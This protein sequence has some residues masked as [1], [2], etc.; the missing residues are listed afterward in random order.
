MFMRY[1]RVFDVNSGKSLGVHQGT[2][3]WAGI[4]SYL[5]SVGYATRSDVL[6]FLGLDWIGTDDGYRA[7]LLSRYRAED[8]SKIGI[9]PTEV[10]YA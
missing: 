9:R 3:E 5:S 10:P 6:D 7:E 8:L 4:L 2:S 1:Y